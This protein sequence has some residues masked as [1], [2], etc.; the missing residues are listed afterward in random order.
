MGENSKDYGWIWIEGLLNRFP[1]PYFAV[2]LFLFFFLN[3]IFYFFST[4]I[5]TLDL[6]EMPLILITCLVIPFELAGLRLQLD[7][8]RETFHYLDKVFSKSQSKFFLQLKEEILGSGK[9]RLVF[10][11]SIGL[12]LIYLSW[13]GFVFYDTQM[14]LIRSG[15]AVYNT[16][17][18]FFNILFDIYYNLILIITIY[19][20]CLVLWIQVN[21]YVAFHNESKNIA[22]RL[23]PYNILTLRRNLSPV[24]NYFMIFLIYFIIC[25]SLINIT[26]F[27]TKLELTF[28]AA[29]LFL[30]FLLGA[31]LAAGGLIDSQRIIKE[32]ASQKLDNINDSLEENSNKLVSMLM[33]NSKEHQEEIDRLKTAIE[34]QRNN[35]EKVAQE[36]I[37]LNIKDALNEVGTFT[38]TIII[39]I[40][41]FIIT[42]FLKEKG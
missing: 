37:G 20:F 26:L 14:D 12:P 6:S 22:G 27:G 7:G 40:L 38:I 9:S 15:D 32:A 25:A 11:L 3:S 1:L 41:S 23:L 34:I 19:L 18:V 2:A 42:Q 4:K 5:E 29:F 17:T 33:G 8:S 16:E 35:W 36:R 24:K 21:T 13:N 30:L 10:I 39:P 28:N 31:S